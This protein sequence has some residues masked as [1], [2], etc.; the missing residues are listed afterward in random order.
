MHRAH[1]RNCV[2][3]RRLLAAL[4]SVTALHAKEVGVAPRPKRVR[5][6]IRAGV[7]IAIFEAFARV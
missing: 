6:Q 2:R 4:F 7:G 3:R 1:R 5:S